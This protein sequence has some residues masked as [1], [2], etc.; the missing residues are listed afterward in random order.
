MNGYTKA[1]IERLTTGVPTLDAILHGGIPTGTLNVITG[2]PGAGKSIL[3][4][5]ILFHQALLGKKD[6]Y[7][8]SI[9]EPSVKFLRYMQ[10]FDFFDPNLFNKNIFFSD[11]STPALSQGLEETMDALRR[12]IEERGPAI[13]AIDSFKALRS[14]LPD[15]AAAQPILYQFVLE[16][17]VSDVSAIIVGE[18]DDHDITHLPEF[19][20]ADSIIALSRQT[21]GLRVSRQLEVLKLRGSGYEPGLHFFD[22]SAAGI[23]VY[24]RVNVPPE[25]ESEEEGDR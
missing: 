16:L 23:T 12:Q 25:G 5:Q 17:A 20:T 14:R 13:I 1:K 19:F 10:Q 3:A 2:G 22:I 6:V 9:A 7:F 18:Y 24:P 15:P 8:T 11:L 21:T 4:L